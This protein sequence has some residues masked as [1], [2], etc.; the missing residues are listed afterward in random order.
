MRRGSHPLRVDRERLAVE[1][2][3]REIVRQRIV[4]EY[5]PTFARWKEEDVQA[6][7][8]ETP[9]V[10]PTALATFIEKYEKLFD[11][12][13]PYVNKVASAYLRD[14]FGLHNVMPDETGPTPG[15]GPRASLTTS[16]S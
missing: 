15:Q 3:N 8:A 14:P 13:Y 7:L 6:I 5:L 1:F 10:D 2:G 12:R 9:N 11:K 4:K 16:I